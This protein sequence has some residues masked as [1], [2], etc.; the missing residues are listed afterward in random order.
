MTPLGVPVL[1]DVYTMVARSSGSRGGVPWTGVEVLTRSSH[2]GASSAGAS[3]RVITGRPSGRPCSHPF[4]AVE[5]P[6]EY[7]RGLA[8]LEDLTDR[9][10]ASVG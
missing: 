8:V 2:R 3:G 7:Q 6:H 10:G 4:E 1:P 9:L 5:L